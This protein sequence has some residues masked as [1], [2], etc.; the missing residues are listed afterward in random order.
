[1]V[2]SGSEWRCKV[3]YGWIRQGIPILELKH[4]GAMRGMVRFASVGSGLEGQG[5]DKREA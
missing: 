5:K 2:W 3:R 1:M 4:G